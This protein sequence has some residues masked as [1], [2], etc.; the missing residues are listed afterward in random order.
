MSPL[1]L[2]AALAALLLAPMLSAA[3]QEPPATLDPAVSCTTKCHEPIAQ[4]DF[5]HQ[6]VTE[7]KCTACH[8]QEEPTKHEFA[9][10]DDIGESCRGCHK[11]DNQ[12]VLHS[13]F[14][15]GDCTSCHDAHHGSS[16]ALL[17]TAD[18]ATLCYVCHESIK[19][20]IGKPFQHGPAAEGFC[21]TCHKAHTSEQ[22]KLLTLEPVELCTKCHSDI[23]EAV[24]AANSVH[25]PMS[26]DC[27]PCHDPHGCEQEHLI[28]DV[29]P[30]L[31]FTCHKELAKAV[32]DSKSPH[33][34]M[35]SARKCMNCHFP[36]ESK[37]ESLLRTPGAAGCATCHDKPQP[38]ASG[39][40]AVAPVSAEV[41]KYKLPH[42]PAKEGKCTACHKPHVAPHP[43]LLGKGFPKRFY[44]PY[45]GTAYELCFECHDK[46]AFEVPKAK[47]ETGF[48]DGDR[49]LHLVHVNDK[50]KGRTCRACHEMHGGDT[51]KHIAATVS[52]GSWALPI[53]WEQMPSGGRCAPGC[54]KP[55]E[56]SREAGGVK[57]R[58]PVAPTPTALEKVEPKAA[59]SVPSPT[60]K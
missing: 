16:K 13:P 19:E 15:S 21:T 14:E 11:I 55:F 23:S 17:R 30:N 37:H 32:G 20:K 31:C 29:Q 18:E 22:P 3:P 44:A 26:M 10:I 34:A 4:G 47:D 28:K 42:G 41:A 2:F 35:T 40:K 36:H 48:R 59:G 49:N 24:D 33:G 51:P 45:E 38:R 52:F 39:G 1:R 57:A 58:S 7:G 43:S 54:H 53:R 6:P 56:Y 50:E 5:L 60:G 12:T 25:A 8:K 46:K 9:P 27:S